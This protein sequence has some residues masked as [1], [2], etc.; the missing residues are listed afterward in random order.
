M[1]TS[2]PDDLLETVVAPLRSAMQDFDT[3]FPGESGARQPVHTVYGGAHLFRAGTARRLGALAIEFVEQYAPDFVSLARVVGLRGAETLPTSAADVSA[4]AAR[5]EGDSD[6][7][8]VDEPDAWL[9]HTV[10]ARVMEKLRREPVEDFRLDFEDGYGNRPDE[11]E[12]ACALSA[13]GE[14]ARGMAEGTLPPFLGIRIK[15]FSRE[16][17]GRGARTLDL[18]LTALSEQTDG[19]LPSNFVVT[20]PK[21]V[22]PDQVAALVRLFEAIESQTSIDEGAL[23]LELMVETPQSIIDSRGVSPLPAIVEAADGRCTGAH[24]G[25]YDYTA[26]CSIT[27]EYQTMGHPACD[28]ARQVM[29]VALAG[30]GIFLSDGATNVLPVPVH[31]RGE[32]DPPLS[33]QQRSENYESVARAWRMHFTDVRHSLETAYYQGWDL[34]PAQL[35]TRYAALYSFFLESLPSGTERLRNFVEK[36]AQATLVGDVFDDA[37]TGQGLLNFFLRGLNCGAITDD[38]ALATGLTEDELRS[39]SFLRI[40]EGRRGDPS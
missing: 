25:V 40:L 4:L 20:L 31:R 27:A 35:V 22:I 33:E 13:A 21:V 34:H 17:V 19:A 26:S 24:F 38:E 28:M 14:V 39:R 23:R 29:Q 30:S 15:P 18:F 37:A 12:D 3:R 8:R 1:K 11:E 32:G 16:L 7:A 36:A 2:I 6:G 10:H 5:I 9:A